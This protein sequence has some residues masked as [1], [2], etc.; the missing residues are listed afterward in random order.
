MS[1]DLFNIDK[2]YED[3][4][5]NWRE[6]SE[7]TC[8]I[9]RA[10]M[11]QP[12]PQDQEDAVWVL[13]HG[14]SRKLRTP[15]EIAL[16]DGAVLRVETALPKHLPIG[17][18]KLRYCDREHET[19]LIVSP[20]LC[21]LPEHLR[22]WGWSTQLYALRSRQSWGIGDFADLRE[23]GRWSAHEFQAG[24]ML[25]NPLGATAPIVPQQPSPYFPSSRIYRNFLY[26]RIEEIPGAEELISDLEELAVI[27]RALNADRRIDR[28]AVF[29]LKKEA[30]ELLWSRFTGDAGFDRY[31]REQGSQLARFATY[32]AL[33]ECHGSDWRQ[34]PEQYQQWN[35]S[36]VARF[37]AEVAETSSFLSVDPMAD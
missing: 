8:S 13:Q 29:R 17:Y 21:Y 9:L 28:N 19:Q 30:L 16:E 35:S 1:T 5:G 36:S 37:T 3:A 10:A 15:A 24:V 4:L 14:Q 12:T 31:C 23:L 7:E 22:I 6:A 18:H 11:G 32:C 34:W 26:L 27:G 2:G 33:A 20:G 25:V